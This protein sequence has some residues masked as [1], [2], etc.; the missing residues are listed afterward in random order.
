M[1]PVLSPAQGDWGTQFGMLIQHISETREGGLASE[2]LDEDV[3][4]LE[5]LYKESKQH[6]D[7][8]ASFKQRAQAAVTKLQSGDPSYLKVSPSGLRLGGVHT[9][10]T[11]ILPMVCCTCS[12]HSLTAA[13]APG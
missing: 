10:S 9:C 8:D 4:N 5:L 3:S 7:A 2:A 6:F 13:H 12:M 1:S 11:L